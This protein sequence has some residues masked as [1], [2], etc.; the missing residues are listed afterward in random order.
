M[1]F[2]MDALRPGTPVR[3]RTALM[4]AAI[5]LLE[6]E[7]AVLEILFLFSEQGVSPKSWEHSKPDFL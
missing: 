4:P 7:G 3:L 5:C 6:K 1:R 2:G